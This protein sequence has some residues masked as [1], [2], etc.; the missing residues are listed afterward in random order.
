MPPRRD[1]ASGT[2]IVSLMVLGCGKKGSGTSS[3]DS[4]TQAVIESTEAIPASQAQP[5]S[6]TNPISVPLTKADVDR[7]E[8]GMAGEMKAIEAA[9]AKMKTART[10][11]DTLNA[12]M[13][14][15]EMATVAAGAKAAG[16][17]AKDLC[18]DS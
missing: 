18:R 7:W 2:L 14:V 3:A 10:G 6:S 16:R 12:M 5:A 8:K 1:L 9:A 17:Q 15:Q 4:E 13:G 11:E